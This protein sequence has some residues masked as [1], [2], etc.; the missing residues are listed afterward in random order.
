MLSLRRSERLLAY[1]DQNDVDNFFKEAENGPG[2]GWDR[3][4][5]RTGFFLRSR[6]NTGAFILPA[7]YSTLVKLWV[8]NMDSSLVVTTDVYT[9]IGTITEVLNEGLCHAVWVTIADKGTQSL[10][11]RPGLAHTLIP[12]HQR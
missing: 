3:P 1:Y 10:G 2:D 5:I 9:Y 4:A 7:L 8:A 11:S 12:F 6:T